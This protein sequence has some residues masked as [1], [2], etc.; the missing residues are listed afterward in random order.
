MKLFIPLLGLLVV[1]ACSKQEAPPPHENASATGLPAPGA[2]AL[3]TDRSLVCMVNDAYMGRPQIPVEVAGLTYYGCC[4]MCK[5]RLAREPATRSAVDP[6]SHRPVDKATA[7]I[8]VDHG[9]TVWY[10]ENEAN[11]A[12]WSGRA[13][14]K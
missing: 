11:Y 2:V 1:S 14:A 6:V 4:E 12:S 13:A 5:T 3:V 8:A 9:G 10:F 7:V